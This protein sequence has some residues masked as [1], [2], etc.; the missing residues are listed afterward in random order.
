MPQEVQFWAVKC[1][2]AIVFIKDEQNQVLYP[3]KESYLEICSKIFL[4]MIQDDKPADFDEIIYCKVIY[5]Y[6]I[7]FNC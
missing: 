7:E 5:I 6:Y 2:E 3:K 4:K 1:L